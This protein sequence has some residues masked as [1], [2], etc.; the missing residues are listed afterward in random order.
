M[1]TKH[2]VTPLI[3]PDTLA[4]TLQ[5][6]P[7]EQQTWTADILVPLTQNICG[8]AAL[9]A[10]G[11]IGF[12][13]VSEWRRLIWY[14]DDA[15][16]W[17]ILLGCAV[18]CAMTVIRFFG[19]DLGLITGAYKAG[20]R[21][22]LPRISALE[23]N[24]QATSDVLQGKYEHT[25]EETRLK[26]VLARARLDAER[27]IRLY[28]E[29]QKIDRKSMVERGMGQRDWERARRLLQ[30]AGVLG[31]DGKFVMQTPAEAI[32]QLTERCATDAKQQAKHRAFT[33]AWK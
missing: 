17:C 3:D 15:L 4:M 26:E 2:V 8:G 29:G 7:Q 23:T 9:G 18:T 28:F 6:Q 5:A 1:P 19:D 33:P 21:S 11:F 27:L 16:L 22:M 13:A 20:Q 32:Q 31:G 14:A 12:V 30:G 24:L 25:S 10:L